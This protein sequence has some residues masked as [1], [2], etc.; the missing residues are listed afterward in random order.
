V[1]LETKRLI[2]REYTPRD[3]NALYEILSDSETDE[4]EALYVYFITRKEWL[5]GLSK[6]RECGREEHPVHGDYASRGERCQKY[7]F[8]LL[9][10]GHPYGI[11]KPV[12]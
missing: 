11:M 2:I 3:F 8:P 5:S 12:P 10:F 6:Q 7:F 4:E 1:I 9:Q